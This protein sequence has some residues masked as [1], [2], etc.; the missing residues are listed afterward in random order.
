MEVVAV[1][2]EI[3]MNQSGAG[4]TVV[5]SFEVRKSVAV[6]DSPVLAVD[7][8][9][10]S[11]CWTLAIRNV[12]PEASD[13]LLS[14]QVQAPEWLRLSKDNGFGPTIIEVTLDPDLAPGTYE[15]GLLIESN[16]GWEQIAITPVTVVDAS[17]VTVV[18]PDN[19]IGDLDPVNTT[20]NMTLPSEGDSEEPEPDPEPVNWAP[21]VLV[22]V[23][24][25]GAVVT[26]ERT[27]RRRKMRR[28][29]MGEGEEDSEN[30]LREMERWTGLRELGAKGA[31]RKE[32]K[33]EE[34][35]TS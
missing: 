22:G 13:E 21:F 7:V 2:E 11:P 25:V 10:A 30:A 12:G 3:V 34:N 24:V 16:V 29:P 19:T 1:Q 27:V 4:G 9:G 17:I 23:L 8:I 28:K 6:A 33:D 26:M 18:T 35:A 5:P 20:M 14:W 31:Y 15:G 32:K